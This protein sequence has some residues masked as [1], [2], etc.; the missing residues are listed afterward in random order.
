MTNDNISPFF[1]TR[2]NYL[3]VLEKPWSTHLKHNH[4]CLTTQILT[5]VNDSKSQPLFLIGLAFWRSKFRYLKIEPG[6]IV[7]YI[8]QRVDLLF[9]EDTNKDLSRSMQRTAVRI[10]RSQRNGNAGLT[11]LNKNKRMELFVALR[12]YLISIFN[13]V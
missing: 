9:S 11:N 4:E 5:L 7:F 2:F 6:V 8:W 3:S 12:L 10:N 1:P 13:L